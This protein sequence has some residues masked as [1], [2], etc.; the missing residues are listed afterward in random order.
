MKIEKFEDLIV[1]QKSQ[2]L[3]IL[4][5]TFFKEN[6]DFSFVNQITRSAV[7]I[8]NNIAEGFER[9]SN[10]EYI[11]FLYIA[12]GSNSET[13]SMLYLA[14]RLQFISEKEFNEAYNLTVE[15]GKMLYSII[16]KISN[17]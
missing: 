15:I 2:D 11:Q 5:Y 8:S 6:K 9:K 12:L 7:S 1:W 14:K 17:K 16:S 3:A 13:K 10:K 4:V